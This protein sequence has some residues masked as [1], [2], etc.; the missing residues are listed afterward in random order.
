MT[1]AEISNDLD[2][3]WLNEDE[4]LTKI[5]KNYLRENMKYIYIHSIYI[6]KNNNIDKITSSVQELDILLDC[7]E[8]GVSSVGLSQ[9]TLAQCIS[10][11]K[12]LSTGVKYN[13]LDILVYNV[14]LEPEHIQNFSK[15]E[16][17]SELPNLFL[18][19]Y[20]G[21]CDIPIP[22]S[23]FIF[24]NLNSVYFIY[25]ECQNA[26]KSILGKSS[27]KKTKKVSIQIPTRIF[28]KTRK[29]HE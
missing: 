21:D 17:L 5:N 24:H 20:T 9:K 27:F 2:L 12:I 13:L 1:N 15:M 10:E 4:R 14:K 3:S 25:Q 28:G 6:N 26:I 19:K 16:N 8:N 7:S 29:Y 22:A 23:I 18:T 11:T